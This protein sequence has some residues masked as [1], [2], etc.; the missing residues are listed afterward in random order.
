MLEHENLGTAR[1]PSTPRDVGASPS[2][3]YYSVPSP[4]AEHSAIPGLRAAAASFSW[5]GR[6]GGAGDSYHEEGSSESD[7]LLGAEYH[8][9][10]YEKRRLGRERDDLYGGIGGEQ[11]DSPHNLSS[12]RDDSMDADLSDLLS[13]AKVSSVV[14]IIN[15]IPH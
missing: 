13:R 12:N 10:E 14:F 2:P 11:R 1:T 3:K 7:E 9:S 4:N 8:P 6:G 15:T 5:L